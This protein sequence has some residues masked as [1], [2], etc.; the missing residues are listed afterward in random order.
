MFFQRLPLPHQETESRSPLL[1]CEQAFGLPQH[2]ELVD[3]MLHDLPRLG[4]KS[5]TASARLSLSLILNLEHWVVM[6]ELQSCHA[7]GKPKLVHG[8]KTTWKSPETTWRERDA[9]QLPVALATTPHHGQFQLQLEPRDHNCMRH[10]EPEPA[11]WLVSYF[12]THRNY[13]K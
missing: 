2:R 6:S 13:E 1:K 11:S 5:H 8:G 9:G 7:V 12:L 4:L 3:M 10:P